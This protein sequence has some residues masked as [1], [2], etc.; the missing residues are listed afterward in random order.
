MLSLR[1]ATT[2]GIAL[3]LLIALALGWMVKSATDEALDSAEWVVRTLEIQRGLESI[4]SELR[5]A[6]SMVRGHVLF[7]DE[8]TLVLYRRSVDA[9]DRRIAVLRGLTSHNPALQRALD[10]LT[11]TAADYFRHLDGLVE[12]RRSGG[13]AAA[14]GGIVDGAGHPLLIEAKSQIDNMAGVEARLLAERRAALAQDTARTRLTIYAAGL[15]VFAILAASIVALRRDNRRRV[16][17][18]RRATELST[19]LEVQVR[20][21]TAGLRE[22]EEQLRLFVEHAPAA[23]AMFDRDMRYLAFS[24]RWL[25]D[26]GL[27]DR[28]ITG[29]SHYEIFPE[30]PQ[31]W[32][33]THARCL[34]GATES[35]EADSFLREDGRMQWMKWFICPW[36]TADGDIG[37]ILIFSED[38]TER[39]LAERKL[40]QYTEQLE[41]LSRRLL[42]AQEDERRAIARELHDEVGQALTAVKLSLATLRRRAGEGDAAMLADLMGIV[43]Q[44]IAQVRDRSLDLRPPMLDDIGLAG[45]LEWLISRLQA[46]V[47]LRITADIAPLAER[48]APEVESAAFRIIQEALTNVLRHAGARAATVRLWQ[49]DG[50]LCLSV[51][52]DGAGF[53]P[54][55]RGTGFGLSGMRERAL[56]LGGEF[57]LDSCHGG[58]AEIRARLPIRPK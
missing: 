4:E 36:Q 10:D 53:D 18:E 38:V 14:R 54:Q 3:A 35:S 49:E 5:T 28:D 17:A 7:G 45:T 25:A 22:R 9:L 39:K 57:M 32:R 20:E 30:I 50:L 11:R 46:K 44:A 34:A 56:L 33:D 16:E 40:A 51:K 31:R 47:S 52:D 48:P 8:E 19:G 6:Q 1:H 37:G 42:K 2:L 58:G 23:I 21:R 29:R 43:D 13:L 55:A 15:L 41:V 27:G 26:Y 24:R 12:L